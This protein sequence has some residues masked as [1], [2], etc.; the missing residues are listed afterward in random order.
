MIHNVQS[1][2]QGDYRDLG[3]EAGASKNLSEGFAEMY[4]QKMNKSID[5]VKELMDAT[6]WYNAKQAKEAGL[7]DEIMFESTPMMVASD[8]LLLSDEAVSKINA[9][10]QNDKESTM[11]IEINPE[12]MESI[13]NLIDEKIAAVKA[14]FEANNS[15]DKPLKN[16]LFKFGGIK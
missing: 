3:N 1:G 9:L 15:A 4:A 16:Q 2:A 7:V 13:K 5:E 10:M 8:D 11:N 12:Q 14:E 6:T